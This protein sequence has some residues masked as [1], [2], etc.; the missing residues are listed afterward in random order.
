[1]L[2]IT[3][4]LGK[5][6]KLSAGDGKVDFLLFKTVFYYVAFTGIEFII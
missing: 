1:M 4:V 6:E 3:F 5:R 2:S